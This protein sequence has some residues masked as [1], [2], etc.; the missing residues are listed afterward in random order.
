MASPAPPTHVPGT[1]LGPYELVSLLGVGAMG[2]VYRAHD[3]RLRREVAVKVL[4]AALSE[5]RERLRRFEQ[6]ARAAGALSHP[7]VV[8]V[9]DLGRSD[10]SWYV[11]S[12]LLQGQT[13]RERLE[14][15]PLPARKAVEYALQAARGLSAAHEKGVVHRD[16]KPE[17]VFLTRD[18]T[19]KI[20]DFGLA[21]L[22]GPPPAGLPEAATAEAPGPAGTEPGTVLGTAGYMAPEQVRGEAADARSDIFALGAILY[23]ML[24]GRRAFRG[25]SAVETM[26][27]V[28]RE[29]PPA[30]GLLRG[31]VPPGLERVVVHCLEKDPAERFQS[32]RDLAFD[33][34]ALSLVSDGSGRAVPRPLPRRRWPRALAVGA[35]LP[36]LG[37]AG[38]VVGLRAPVEPPDYARVTFRRGTVWS[39]R[40]TAD[41]QVAYS[42]SW[43]GQPAGVHVT[44][45]GSP[46]SRPLGQPGADLVGATRQGDLFLL[47]GWQAK[48]AV[49]ARVPL[50]GGPPREIAEGVAVADVAADGER[51]AVVRSGGDGTR[52][53]SPPGKPLALVEGGVSQVRLSP[54]GRRLA[55]LEHRIPG[56][57]R[58]RVTILDA[59]G[60]TVARS[61]E[62]ASA[63]GL[64]WSPGG[65]EIWFSAARVGSEAAL[66]AMDG[67]G[68]ERLLTQ[69]PGRL[70][71][72]DVD[73]K[74]RALVQR[75]AAR[76][77]VRI[78]TAGDDAER[79]LSW[80][81]ATTPAAF[82]ADGRKLLFFEGGEGGGGGYAVYLRGTDGALPVRLGQ[83][84]ALD[85]SRDGRL[86]LA[87]PLDPPARLTLLPTGAGEARS[88]SF[89]GLT[90]FL[91]ARLHPDGR[92]LLAV[93]L[94]EKAPPRLLEV[95]VAGGPPRPLGPE[96]AFPAAV[97]ALSPDGSFL[98]V[99]MPG[100]GS[101]LLSLADGGLRPIP[102]LLAGESLTGWTGDSHSLYVRRSKG[103][104]AFVDRLD[105][106]TGARR[107]WRELGP[108]DRAGVA[109]LG[110]V[111]PTPDGE[112]YVYSYQRRLSDLYV[113]TGLR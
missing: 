37:G 59:E 80:F 66:W 14:A 22:Q 107:P 100:Q 104:R 64:S 5:D 76:H 35:L 47:L 97:E 103:A 15:G 108:A 27:T 19:V 26:N 24:T 62:F 40:F 51:I 49:L 23:E 16:L 87:V 45:P 72:H 69:A 28:L 67:R 101:S 71:L 43:E 44:Q 34:E 1:R 11:V 21:K 77:E 110:P 55:L 85:L 42:A 111:R 25:R 53:E 88:L 20:F 73:E 65:R 9:H 54:D 18:G 63:T 93:G 70:V 29:E 94:P 13:L 39:A 109:S 32:A 81:D 56:D 41:G 105:V 17:N 86:A 3:T 90:G 60:R 75:V 4:P 91:W 79:D 78:R 74:G 61:S 8:A 98:A 58:G 33:L 30:I 38:F 31:D 10:D 83:G 95:P 84:R 52:V 113:V 46:E 12:E 112:G 6:E 7:N 102:G 57:D 36:A 68:R 96:G 82:S 48:G 50:S 89:P 99:G 106:A 92:R 2:E